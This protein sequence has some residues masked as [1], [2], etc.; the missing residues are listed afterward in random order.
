MQKADYPN[1]ITP[2]TNYLRESSCDQRIWLR[3]PRGRCWQTGRMP[4]P[5]CPAPSTASRLLLLP[6]MA[7]D[8][9]LWRHQWPALQAAAPGPVAVADV[10]GRADSLPGMAALLL[11]EQPG[12][13]LLAGCS[14]GGMLAMEVARQAPQRVRGLALLGTTA[15]PDT[16]E[17]IALRTSAIAEFE[18]G[19]AEALLRAN[20]LF[21]FHRAHQARLADDYL[22]MVLRGGV[23][24]LIRQNRAVMARADLRPAL[25]AIACPTLVVGGA[26]DQLTPPD[27]SREIAAGIPG[28]QLHLLPECGH[29]LT[30]EQ[31]QAVTRLLL[32]W[33]A[34]MA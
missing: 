19:R 15:R 22:A 10:H 27:C 7:C 11:A 4:L 9:D 32:D 14:L 18:A 6:G 8:A 3:R 26:D 13:L 17:L 29:M 16:P 23:S 30:W 24:A 34:R 21:A 33:L 20:V 28:A 12:P 31:P 5:P 25:P 1:P 2:Q